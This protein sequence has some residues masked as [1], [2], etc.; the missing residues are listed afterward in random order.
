MPVYRTLVGRRAGPWRCAR[1]RQAGTECAGAGSGALRLQE[2][3]GDAG[4]GLADGVPDDG[5][6]NL[7]VRRGVTVDDDQ[8]GAGLGGDGAQRGGGLDGE[9]AADGQEE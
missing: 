4:D 5:G 8:A 6:G 2:L 7:V 9:R 1:L 3:V